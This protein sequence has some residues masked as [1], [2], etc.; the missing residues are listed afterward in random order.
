MQQSNVKK[1]RR[2]NVV[3]QSSEIALAVL[4]PN[5]NKDLL[6]QKKIAVCRH[7]S[8]ENG[9]HASRIKR[10]RRLGRRRSFG[11]SSTTNNEERPLLAAVRHFGAPDRGDRRRSRPIR[12]E[13]DDDDD[14]RAEEAPRRRHHRLGRAQSGRGAEST[15]SL[16]QGRRR[17]R[18]LSDAFRTLK[19][20]EPSSMLIDFSVE[21]KPR[22]KARNVCIH[23]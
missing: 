12:P 22:E 17:H 2:R 10:L 8:T 15:L 16:A 21:K 4:R 11:S 1:T 6:K 9:R 7:D 14:S 19:Y 18:T 20:R 3:K 23:R 13:T 5:V